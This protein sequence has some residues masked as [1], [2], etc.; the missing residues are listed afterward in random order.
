MVLT[1]SLLIS[2]IILFGESLMGVFNI[3]GLAPFGVSTAVLLT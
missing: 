3:L 1:G 2:V